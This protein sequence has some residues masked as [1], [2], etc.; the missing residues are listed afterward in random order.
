M[1]CFIP[2]TLLTI[3]TI[4]DTSHAITASLGQPY[5]GR[6]VNGVAFPRQFNG[7]QLRET[8]RTYT[9]PEVVGA[10]LDAVDSVQ[11]Q[12]PGSPNL[13]FGDFS[14]PNGGAI[15]GHRSHQNGRD[16]DVGMYAKG[17]RSLDTFLPMNEENLDVPRTWAFIESLICS[18]RVQYVFVDR[19]I[20]TL[21][22][23]YAQSRGMDTAYLDRLFANNRGSVIQH[24][25]N[26][27]DHMHIRFFTPWSTMAAQVGD[28]DDQ[29]RSVI[30]MAQQS[31]LP[32]KVF[33]YAKG[34]EKSLDALAQ[35]FGVQRGDLCRWNEI[36]G[37]EVLSPGKCLVFYK[38][39][40]ELEPVHLAQSLQPNS[41][42]ESP[43]HQYAALRP[44]PV[45]ASDA[46]PTSRER[47]QQGR[48][49]KSHDPVTFTYKTRR[50]DTIEKIAR[51]NGIEPSVLARANGMKPGSSLKPGQK[52]KLAGMKFS[53]G[54][55]S[56]EVGWDRKA[57]RGYSSPSSPR[58]N[59]GTITRVSTNAPASS[60]S[61][62][63]KSVKESAARRGSS[64]NRGKEPSVGFKG[65]RTSVK[66][67]A[68]KSG[69]RVPE[70]LK[71][72]GTGT[73]KAQP[74]VVASEKSRQATAKMA[75]AT[76]S[77]TAPTPKPA[78]PGPKTSAASKEAPRSPQTVK[79][80]VQTGIA[81]NPKASDRKVN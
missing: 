64:P 19:R 81:K 66:G 41:V 3:P 45:S 44:V 46:I 26:H 24:V 16:V 42:P 61:G 18:Q 52:I 25:R 17:S 21:L 54:P 53:S 50:G 11:K 38:R 70:K 78:S 77:A 28:L 23:E 33:Y 68:P 13:Y 4:T 37:S 65:A 76:K 60:R 59:S 12:F 1:L 10:M 31:Y 29:K 32:K 74:P 48:E 34:N 55:S 20:Q 67:D 27:V 72:G 30:E 22:Y 8:D 6:L 56:C 2:L 71:P 49:K 40:F 58:Q 36:R 5:H 63:S 79:T 62:V 9:T 35:S 47:A 7:Y 69:A 14:L 51:R 43:A 57:A 39:G 80:G 75:A 15:G 73:L